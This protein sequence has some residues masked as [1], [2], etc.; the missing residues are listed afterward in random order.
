MIQ[1]VDRPLLTPEGADYVEIVHSNVKNLNPQII[2][3]EGQPA[4]LVFYCRNCKKVIEKPERIT[5]TLRFKCPECG[6]DRVSFGGR[7]SVQ[8]YY[9]LREERREAKNL[10]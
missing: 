7:E 10:L 5:K 4:D 3:E 8:N 1:P 6:Q 9:K 2:Q